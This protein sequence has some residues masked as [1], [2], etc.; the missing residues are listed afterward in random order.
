MRRT[1]EFDLGDPRVAVANIA[2][3]LDQLPHDLERRRFARVVDVGLVG[4]PKQ[5]QPRALDRQ[6]GLI[7]GIRDLLDDEER[8]RRVDLVR[9]LDQPSRVAVL[10]QPPGEEVGDDGD[11]VAPEAR[12]GVVRE[13][14]ERLRGGGLDHFPGRDPEP[15]A[16]QGKL[17]RERD[18]DRAERVLV[19]L[20]GLGDHWA[21]D[22]LHSVDDLLVQQRG[23]PKALLCD[24]GD[25]LGGVL[26]RERRVA[27][28]DAFRRVAEEEV[29]AHLAARPLFEDRQD[30][31]LRR[32]RM[33]RR[34]EDDQHS[35]LDVRADGLSRGDDEVE[36][37]RTRL[38]ERRRDADRQGV[39]I[40][41]GCVVRC[42]AERHVEVLVPLA[43][44]VHE[45]RLARLDGADALVVQV[46]AGDVEAGLG[47]GHRERQAG[48]PEADDADRRGALRDAL[49][50]GRFG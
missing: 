47:E 21:R 27:G 41:D 50:E 3:A 37:G 20:R 2:A 38:R 8:H 30:D 46:D 48:V 4:H 42:R 15:V 29:L 9:G 7:Q 19:Q 40:G 36:V 25:E 28:I 17:V 13:E 6:A 14:A 11:A 12:A 1:V 31:L 22:G 24:A 45:V 44:H 39:E 49:V 18:V 10:A 33:R 16:H 5:Q 23:A 26:D 32:P 35:R 43:G 34:L